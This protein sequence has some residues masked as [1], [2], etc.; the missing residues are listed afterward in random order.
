MAADG[1]HLEEA[2]APVTDE[3]VEQALSVLAGSDAENCSYPRVRKASCARHCPA[4]V[5]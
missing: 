4:F 1:Q 5:A 3:E 2:E